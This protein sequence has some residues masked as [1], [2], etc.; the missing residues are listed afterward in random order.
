MKWLKDFKTKQKIAQQY[1][2][3]EIAK[4]SI[5]LIDF[6]DTIYIA[7]ND[8]PLVAVEDNWTKKEILDKLTEVRTNYINFKTKQKETKRP[9]A[10]FL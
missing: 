5:G 1:T 7:I 6:N 8:T 2:I 9:S 10:L 3:Q 4:G